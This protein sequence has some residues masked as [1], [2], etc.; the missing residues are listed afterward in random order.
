[1][2]PARWAPSLQVFGALLALGTA[3]NASAQVQAQ[4]Q[5]QAQAQPPPAAQS[6]PTPPRVIEGDQAFG[7]ALQLF[8]RA[9][10]YD[11]ALDLLLS[12]PDLVARPEGL[13][14][15]VELLVRLGQDEAA[16]SAIETYLSAHPDDAVAR[17]QL[18]E[19][20]FK[21]RHD[22]AATLAYRLALAGGL[23]PFRAG[24]TRTRLEAI[25]SRKSLRVWIG[26]S[27]APDSNVNAGTDATHVDLYGLPFQLDDAARRRGG[28]GVSGY[29]GVEK[30][31]RVSPTL[32]VR[33]TGIFSFNALPGDD[34][35]NQQLSLRLG[36]EWRVGRDATIAVQATASESWFGGARLERREGLL[37]EGDAYGHDRRW[38]AILTADNIRQSLSP[39][40][41]G[42]SY[43]IDLSRTR[44]LSTSTLWRLN[45]GVTRR[46]SLAGSESYWE[47]QVGVGRLFPMPLASL[48]YIEA[49]YDERRFD[50]AAAAFGLTRRDQEVRLEA[51]VSK[52]D[53]LI[54]GS[55]PYVSARFS[56]NRSNI[57]LYSYDRSRVEFGFTREF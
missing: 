46:D 56:R 25:N 19:I 31:F 36:P 8:L 16:L 26:G 28:V 33:A 37:A 53:L 34:L 42:R 3:R 13:R 23:D 6:G 17:F 48:L 54:L 55:H 44:Y 4:A 47:G 22:Q 35:D 43:A 30:S 2:I 20:H 39:T 51:R 10:E 18:A 11:H 40:R 14:L 12:R 9:G 32:F 5:A 52:R 45:G 15:R 49:G 38:R 57:G 24:V 21:H 29:G 1:M 50:A 41:D 7:L 27:I